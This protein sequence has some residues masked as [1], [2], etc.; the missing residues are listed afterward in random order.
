MPFSNRCRWIR[1]ALLAQSEVLTGDRLIMG[2]R[3]SSTSGL[4][5]RS[6]PCRSFRSSCGLHG[7]EEVVAIGRARPELE[8]AH[9]ELTSCISDGEPPSPRKALKFRRSKS[10]WVEESD[11][12][13]LTLIIEPRCQLASLTIRPTQAPCNGDIALGS[14]RGPHVARALPR[15]GDSPTEGTEVDVMGHPHTL[16]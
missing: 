7:A 13:Y 5:S 1:Y 11:L 14:E 4:P 12:L 3:V 15:L 6:A 9:L 2:G 10:L 8:I 16:S